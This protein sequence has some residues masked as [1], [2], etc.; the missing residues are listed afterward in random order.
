[1]PSP[2]SAR[3]TETYTAE[4]GWVTDSTSDLG[5]I[6][7]QQDFMRR[8]ITQILDTG[9]FN[10][11]VAGALMETM[12]EYVVTDP[13]LTPR[14]MLELAG[15]LSQ[16]DPTAIATYQIETSG[17]TIQGNSVLEPML[18]GANMQ[19][20]LAVFRG[21]ATLAD[22]PDQVFD[23]TTTELSASTSLPAVVAEEI[24]IG[25][26]PDVNQVCR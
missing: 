2:M 16:I 12:S 5:R 24:L 9:A 4:T 13:G 17:T 3:A 14:K 20:I 8:T 11:D 19:A 25:V 23:T 18:D 6:S 10:P 15:V 1:M 7:R 22:A 21:W 26:T